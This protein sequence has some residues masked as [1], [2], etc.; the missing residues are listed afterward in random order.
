VKPSDVE[1]LGHRFA[2]LPAHPDVRRR[3]LV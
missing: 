1:E 3:S 2:T